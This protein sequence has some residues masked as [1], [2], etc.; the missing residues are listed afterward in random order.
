MNFWYNESQKPTGDKR[1][2]V[3]GTAEAGFNINNVA[4]HFDID[5]TITST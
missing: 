2:W 5:K 1:S 3:I 4:F